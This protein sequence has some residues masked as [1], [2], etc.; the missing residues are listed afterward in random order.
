M[1][2]K[3][4]LD[5]ITN[6]GIYGAMGHKHNLNT[7]RTYYLRAST[8]INHILVTKS[9]LTSII[10]AGLLPLND[11]IQSDYRELWIDLDCKQFLST[12]SYIFESLPNVYLPKMKKIK[13][14]CFF[15]KEQF[16]KHNTKHYI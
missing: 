1:T 7:P 12:I 13:N 8:T 15:L 3:Y 5:L 9:I 10:S 16:T 14:C 6:T 2:Y 4:M 11:G